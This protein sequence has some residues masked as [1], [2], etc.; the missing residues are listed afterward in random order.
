MEREITTPVTFTLKSGQILLESTFYVQCVDY[1]I[2]V[3]TLVVAKIAEKIQVS[4]KTK[5]V[6]ASK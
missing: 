5:Y 1:N 3:P 2:E 4:V 6:P